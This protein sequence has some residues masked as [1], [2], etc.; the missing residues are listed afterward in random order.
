MN[1]NRER[2]AIIRPFRDSNLRNF[3]SRM[4]LPMRFHTL[5]IAIR[6]RAYLKKLPV[7]RTLLY[8]HTQIR[9]KYIEFDTLAYN[10]NWS[11][12]KEWIHTYH[13]PKLCFPVSS[14]KNPWKI[15]NVSKL[16][17]NISSAW[18]MFCSNNS[19]L[20]SRSSF[21]GSS[22]AWKNPTCY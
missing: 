14:Y 7:I 13:V 18:S 1:T 10:K 19:L 4:H 6:T 16:S 11:S 12:R 8:M 9:E 2:V 15:D 5:N 3:K 22:S 17:K 20:L 21:S